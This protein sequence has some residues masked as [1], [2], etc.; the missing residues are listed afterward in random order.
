MS[1][2]NASAWVIPEEKQKQ[3]L[4]KLYDQNIRAFKLNEVVTFIGVLEFNT[5]EEVKGVEEVD[6]EGNSQMAA[7]EDDHL[8][9]TGIPNE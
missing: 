4:I 1:L 3:C 7:V 2:P 6:A 8:M 5:E 9:Q